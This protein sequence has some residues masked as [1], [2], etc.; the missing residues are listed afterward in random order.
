EDYLAERTQAEFMEAL[1]K[2]RSC[3]GAIQATLNGNE[4][5]NEFAF[6][7]AFTGPIPAKPFPVDPIT[8]LE[9]IKLRIDYEREEIRRNH[10]PVTT[11][12]IESHFANKN[13][14]EVN[15]S[16]AA[17]LKAESQYLSNRPPV[18]KVY[19]YIFK[20]LY[21]I[22]FLPFQD[23]FEAQINGFD[24]NMFEESIKLNVYTATTQP[25]Q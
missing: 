4:N 15:E 12:D 1:V 16:V 21:N 2:D 18:S 7:I 22:C 6:D 23:T 11:E 13:N 10:R 19:I 20:G 17:F 25:G 24:T 8:M 14:T 3:P 9:A 5:F